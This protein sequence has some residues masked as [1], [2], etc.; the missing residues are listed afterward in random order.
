MEKPGVRLEKRCEDSLAMLSNIW[1]QAD[2]TSLSLPVIR[3]FARNASRKIVLHKS[4]VVEGNLE[5][6]TLVVE[7]GATFNGQISQSG[8][9]VG[10]DDR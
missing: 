3:D 10:A 8:G 6:A 5:A 7:E 1:R 9:P 4:A 2:P